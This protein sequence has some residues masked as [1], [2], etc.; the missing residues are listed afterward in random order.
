I[1]PAADGGEFSNYGQDLAQ[2]PVD[3]GRL[4]GVAKKVADMAGW[5]RELPEGRGLGI[6]AHRSFLSYVGAVAEVSVDA[7][8]KI[9]VEDMWIC[10][11]AGLVVN[12]DRVHSQMEGAA[13]FGMSLALHGDITAQ[14]GAVVEGNFDT[15]PVV[16]IGEVPRKI[17]THIMPSDELPGG[18]G[19]PGVPPIAPAIVNAYFAASGERVREL[20][21]RN[22]GLV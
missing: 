4:A 1:D 14:G 2:H 8:G 21:L 5:G 9:R 16:R 22:L 19:E 6:A 10:I 7:D 13:I 15:Y 3:T 17:H 18:V 11:D 12:P 20:P